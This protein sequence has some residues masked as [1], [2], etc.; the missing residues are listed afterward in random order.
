MFGVK[1]LAAGFLFCLHHGNGGVC[2][3]PCA[4]ASKQVRRGERLQN[5][6]SRCG[7]RRSCRAAA[8]FRRAAVT[9]GCRS[10]L[11]YQRPALS[12][13]LTCAA[14]GNRRRQSGFTKKEMAQDI[15]ALVENLG[16]KKIGLVGHDI[17]PMVAYAY[18]AHILM[19]S[20]ALS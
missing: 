12:S 15:H 13:R 17:G 7:Q 8:W 9:C 4:G 11:N 1:K 2:Y 16:F 19:K 18:A 20:I 10:S 5:A 3:V 6:L 14:S